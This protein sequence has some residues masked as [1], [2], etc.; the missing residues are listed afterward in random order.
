MVA[1]EGWGQW[2]MG[3]CC[4]ASESP[5]PR[6]TAGLRVHRAISWIGRAEAA[7]DDDAR[8]LFLWIGFNAAYAD[9]GEV[10]NAAAPGRDAFKDFFQRVVALDAGQRIYDAIWD[11]F[12]G[13]I[14]VLLHNKYVF[15]PFW[16][17]H[18]GVAGFED[19]EEWFR[20]S[21]CR[22][23]RALEERDTVRVLRLVFDRL[24]VLRNQIVHGGATWNSRVNRDQVRDGAAILAFL[25]P[26]F[27]D[28]MMDNPHEDWGRPFYPV[29][30]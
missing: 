8:F 16:K 18:N 9:E 3:G 19:W 11:N 29:V 25:M 12:S 17:H 5:W 26:V 1:K 30:E 6:R 24:Y 15:T 22:F 21:E 7:G 27:V 10:Q 2:T 20:A 4:G 23:R 28:V 13:P 14:R